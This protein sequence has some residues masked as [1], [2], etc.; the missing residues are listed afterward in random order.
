MVMPFEGWGHAVVAEPGGRVVVLATSVPGVEYG[1]IRLDEDGVL[2]GTFGTGGM[3]AGAGIG[4]A[5]RLL[6]SDDGSYL[7]AGDCDGA[8]GLCLVRHR[9]DGSVDPGFGGDGRVEV[10]D[11]T[12]LSAGDAAID[13]QG[14]IVITGYDPT[15]T[16]D[17]ATML[18]FLPDGR[19]DLTFGSLGRLALRDGYEIFGGVAVRIDGR[20]AAIAPNG[21]DTPLDTRV[22]V[23]HDGGV[24]D[25]GF[26]NEG[27]AMLPGFS[28][29]HV[30]ARSDGNLIL[31]GT[32]HD[33]FETRQAV[34][35]IGVD[36][37]LDAMF[38][39]GGRAVLDLGETG[40][41][42]L[43]ASAEAVGG[44]TVVVGDVNGPTDDAVV[45]QLLDDGTLDPDFVGGFVVFGENNRSTEWTDVA[46]DEYGRVVVV[47]VAERVS[48][49]P[50]EIVVARY[51]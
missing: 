36:G 9:R 39:N 33:G 46:V 6:R 12:M 40:W 17:R 19:L 14:R 26:G 23:F 18:R 48:T 29:L 4:F 44:R 32:V 34:V 8:G 30:T 41:G 51:R 13:D 37:Q 22:L 35:R 38:G 3:V 15:A 27:V 43:A 1:L 24:A 31:A 47:G 11:V 25:P 28:A 21:Q 49:Q 10:A 45:A 5:N 7:V 20:I 2:D 42:S 16:P 50:T